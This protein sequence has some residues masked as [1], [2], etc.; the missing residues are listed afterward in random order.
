MFKIEQHLN[1]DKKFDRQMSLSKTKCWYSNNCLNFLKHAVPLQIA[2]QPPKLE[3]KI[4][5][6]LESFGFQIILCIF[7]Y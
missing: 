7:Y 4:S 3:K 5:T 2:Q 1:E 6:D